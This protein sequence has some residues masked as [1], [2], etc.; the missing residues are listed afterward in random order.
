MP[1]PATAPGR[2]P[3][4]SQGSPGAAGVH[5]TTR[6]PMPKPNR[7]AVMDYASHA[8][9]LSPDGLSTIAEC[10]SCARSLPLAQLAPVR[11]RDGQ[12]HTGAS[13]SG[14]LI[15]CRRRARYFATVGKDVA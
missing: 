7:Q 1:I 11:V 9:W 8:G 13:E 14:V 3:L 2:K 10:Q 5:L 4:C 6:Y 12:Q 15:C